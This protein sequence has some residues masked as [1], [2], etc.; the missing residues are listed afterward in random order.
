MEFFTGGFWVESAAIDVDVDHVARTSECT[1]P[2][3]V[4]AGALY[5]LNCCPT[6]SCYLRRGLGQHKPLQQSEFIMSS[7]EV[8]RLLKCGF[9][10]MFAV[11]E[12]S[13]F[14]SL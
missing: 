14:Q 11:F 5:I 7:K 4:I 2:G 3:E 12:R 13:K 8:R 10:C 6:H 9:N 1:W